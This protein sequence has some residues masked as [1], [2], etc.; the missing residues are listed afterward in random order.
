MVS[1][2]IVYSRW[3]V[4]NIHIFGSKLPQGDFGPAQFV[5]FEYLPLEQLCCQ[6]NDNLGT[7]GWLV[8]VYCQILLNFIFSDTQ[9]TL[10]NLPL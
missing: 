10:N 4:Y 2:Y 8:V 9:C 1:A 6:S 5:E 7:E 3:T